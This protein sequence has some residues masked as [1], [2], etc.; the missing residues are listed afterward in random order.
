[1][2]AMPLRTRRRLLAGL[3]ILACAAVAA[4]AIVWVQN[5]RKA[6]G[7]RRAEAARNLS[8]LV[9][10]SSLYM[11]PGCL[12]GPRH[13]PSL[14]VCRSSMM[15]AVLSVDQAFEVLTEPRVSES[16]LIDAG[17]TFARAYPD[18]GPECV[19]R[20]VDAW[21]GSGGAQEAALLW[22]CESADDRTLPIVLGAVR[23]LLGSQDDGAVKGPASAFFA[24]PARVLCE[25]L[26]DPEPVLRLTLE[27]G[28][29][30]YWYACA[31]ALKDKY[32]IE[33]I[34]RRTKE[35]D[36]WESCARRLSDDGIAPLRT[37]VRGMLE[38][39]PRPY[40][41]WSAITTLSELSDTE[42][43]PDL[44]ELLASPFSDEERRSGYAALIRTYLAKLKY[45]HDPEQLMHIV[46]T[47]RESYTVLDW[48]VW[49]LLWLKSDRQS[50]HAALSKNRRTN[51]AGEDVAEYVDSSLLRQEEARGL[52]E[53][54]IWSRLNI[55]ILDRNEF[56]QYV[57][58]AEAGAEERRALRAETDAFWRGIRLGP[59]LD[60]ESL[61]LGEW[62]RQHPAQA[63]RLAEITEAR[64]V[65][66][67]DNMG[68]YT[69]KSILDA[70]PAR[71]SAEGS[72]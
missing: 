46:E 48:A 18:G 55:L 43:I 26:T 10:A 56:R 16:L 38:R 8:Q 14:S 42:I 29:S 32:L 27:A 65:L 66:W 1:M 51:N 17:R 68:E 57:Q 69:L 5:T 13:P 20:L 4:G 54:A 59:G 12:T 6:E 63:R 64:E 21:S 23:E 49:R 45:Q 39:D 22:A 34:R 37:L 35:I 19:Q 11:S 71:P 41:V 61:T 47:E 52:S 58:D 62:E 30:V 60:Y 33:E 50:I 40:G 7:I 3:S 15:R 28:R 31:P 2:I 24:D 36:S 53:G 25:R 9:I 72:D 67:R 70:A 44:E